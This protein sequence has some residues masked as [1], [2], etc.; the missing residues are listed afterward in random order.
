[1]LRM[2][3][4]VRCIALIVAL[5]IC[6]G[7]SSG[8]QASEGAKRSPWVGKMLNGTKCDGGQVPFGPFDYLLR[9]NFR[10]QLGVVEEFHFNED[11]EN[12]RKG[13]SGTP[14][15][16]IHY[17]LQTWPNHHRAL[18]SALRYRLQ[19]RELW[20]VG[21]NTSQNYPAECYLQRAMNFSPNDP[22]PYMLHG[23]LMHQMKQYDVALKSYRQAVRLQPNDLITQYNMG[24]T[25]VELKK[26]AEAQQIANKVYAADFPLPGLK[27]KL[28]EAKRPK[29][30]ADVAKPAA[31]AP[32]A[33]KPADAKPGNPAPEESKP[34]EKATQDDDMPAVPA[35]EDTKPAVTDAK[36]PES[37]T[38]Q[39]TATGQA[40]PDGQEAG[41]GQAATPAEAAA[42]T[43]PQLT[44]EQMA[45]LKQ[46]LQEQAEKKKET[47]TSA[48]P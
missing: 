27:R 16:D 10:E 1:M 17:T 35:D 44:P 25:L 30:K 3:Q 19:H 32:V 21:D 23:L 5:A 45:T 33:T 12:L 22:I 31:K 29:A 39:E 14:M 4:S 48:T 9:N 38:A 7:I 46:A 13:L 15:G 47:E 40:S 11:V 18:N 41:G 2:T 8:T 37:V 43:T 26:F 6:G 20:S 34:Q 36:T 42:Q 24:L 28:A